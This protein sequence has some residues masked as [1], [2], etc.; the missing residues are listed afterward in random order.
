MAWLKASFLLFN[1]PFCPRRS[2]QTALSNTFY[3]N[4]PSVPQFLRESASPARLLFPFLGGAFMEVT[5]GFATAASGTAIE[6]RGGGRGGEESKKGSLLRGTMSVS[7][8]KSLSRYC[9]PH[10]GDTG[11]EKGREREGGREERR[12]VAQLQQNQVN[13]SLP[14][15][16]KEESTRDSLTTLSQDGMTDGRTSLWNY[17]REN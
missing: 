3:T 14:L 9:A 4:R 11:S 2:P 7:F 6:D 17:R 5:I 13:F 10:N 15:A 16:P 12:R 8:R 1:L